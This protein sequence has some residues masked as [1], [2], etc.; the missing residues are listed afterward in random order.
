MSTPL[1]VLFLEDHPD[2]VTL[3]LHELE[4]AGYEPEWQR[5]ETEAEYVAHIG[6]GYEIIL[7]D[8]N[9]PQFNAVR[10]LDILV[11]SGLDIPYII[12]S[13]SI[14]EEIAV[15]CMKKGASDYLLKDRLARLGP[16]VT[17]SL[18]RKRLREEKLET[19]VDLKESEE[20]YRNVVEFLP[21][22]IF[23]HQGGSIIYVNTAAV[24]LLG[25]ERPE[26][27]VGRDSLDFLHPDEVEVFNQ[28][29]KQL[30]RGERTDLVEQK[31][32]RLDG[33]VIAVEAC[34]V[35]ITYEGKPASLAVAHDIAERKQAEKV[36]TVLHRISQ[37]ASEASDLEELLRDI[38]QWLGTLLDI[39]NFY[40]G[41]Y[42]P[43]SE[44]YSFPYEVDQYDDFRGGGGHQM[45]KSLT[46]YV[47]RTGEPLLLD[48]IEHQ[49][50]IAAGEVEMV[51][52][53]AKSWLGVPLK[54][55]QDVLGVV[56]MQSYDENF[57]YTQADLELIS[58]VSGNIAVAVERKRAEEA[59]LQSEERYRSLVESSPFAVGGHMKGELFYV[60]PAAV[61]MMGAESADDLLGMNIMSLVHPD[62][63]EIV[64]ERAR[65][66][67]EE[68]KPQP[69]MVEKFLR[70]DGEVIDVEVISIPFTYQGKP[71]TQVVVSDVTER[72]RAEAALQESQ[73]R[74][75][76]VVTSSPLILFAIDK[77]GDFI[78]SEGRGLDAL[79]LKPGQVTGQSAYELYKDVPQILE[80]IQRVLEGETF[81]ED[82]EV[83]EL[84]Y[85]SW[86]APL[87][88]EEGEI[89]GVIGVSTDITARRHRE[90]ELEAV[91]Q[92]STALRVAFAREDI[93]PIVLDQ[94][95]EMFDGDGAA[96]VVYDSNGEV[97]R[98]LTIELGDGLWSDWTG[99][100]LPLSEGVTGKVIRTGVPY[101]HTNMA[102]MAEFE[103]QDRLNG[104]KAAACVPLVAEGK[105][106]GAF[107]LGRLTTV[108]ED[109]LRLFTAI[110]DMIANNL[111]R[112]IL[113]D[114]LEMSYIETVLAL[115]RAM[116]ARDTYTSDHS[117]RLAFWAVT[118]AQ[119]LGCNEEEVQVI[120]WASLL[121]DIGKIGVPDEILSKPGPLLE[122]EWEVMRRHP[123]IGAE[124]VAPVQKL[125]DV[126]P[127][128]RAH[129]ERYDGAGYP[130][131]L[132]GEEIP[133]AARI[134]AVVDAYGAITDDRVYRAARSHE[135]A[136]KELRDHSGSQFDPQVVEAFLQVIEEERA[137]GAVD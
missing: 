103:L 19:E 71:A 99:Q 124:I 56:A 36:Q 10:A 17:E 16:A 98:E 118:T 49:E 39:S 74:L 73:E 40:V 62:Y 30:E 102:Q 44:T 4:K 113:T 26:D 84:V 27:L 66:S 72:K 123:E 35:P 52:T 129:Q 43:E 69:L 34:S 70:L 15:E 83:G 97:D 104:V 105:V 59:L 42:D 125:S 75:T 46:D 87:R 132:K 13:G 131:Q 91:V 137:K 37:A 14:S 24:I 67:Q 8:Y 128:I 96:L 41:L 121:H 115:A 22:A 51:G 109:E 116:D 85:E 58:F 7:A 111:Y 48:E 135:E 133:R 126:A 119:A 54:T 6:T 45:P 25:A 78:L 64:A 114:R 53:P 76:Y 9:L 110:G 101:Y 11:E 57:L 86:Y 117:Q 127:V 63:R 55:T 95:L 2:D 100:T 23:I 82:V 81:I 90:R 31:L 89:S 1:N 60:N 120:R 65:Q 134:L 3:M 136:V 80:A 77:E 106:I 20:R 47:R 122:V 79:G 21:D 29:G 28:R 5:V 38:H 32:V 12:V 18:R 61:K 107:W 93:P 108:A 130:D 112:A 94:L 50:L 33:Q 92:T 68:G 88:D